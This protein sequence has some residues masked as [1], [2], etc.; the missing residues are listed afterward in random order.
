VLSV[1][2]TKT[3]YRLAMASPAAGAD[4]AYS[5]AIPRDDAHLIGVETKM[6]NRVVGAVHEDFDA[7]G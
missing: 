7:P 2:R 1:V 4:V 5:R 6:P 3:Q